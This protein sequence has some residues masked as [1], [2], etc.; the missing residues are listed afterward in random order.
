MLRLLRFAL[1]VVLAFLALGVVIAIASSTTG[2]IEK[3]VLIAA[4]GGLFVAAVPVR[5]I[6]V[7]HS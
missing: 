7:P 2:P 6:G 3:V 4:L 5:R 1:L